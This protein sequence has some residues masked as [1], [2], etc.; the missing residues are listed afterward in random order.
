MEMSLED[1]ALAKLK[2]YLVAMDEDEKRIFG[3]VRGI[4]NVFEKMLVGQANRL[5]GLVEPT[6]EDLSEIKAV[7]FEL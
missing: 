2:N 6:I 3:N 7:D 5:S 4:R 1:E